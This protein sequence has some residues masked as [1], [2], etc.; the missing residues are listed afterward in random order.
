MGSSCR[1]TFVNSTIVLGSIPQK[2]CSSSSRVLK[3]GPW[4]VAGKHLAML[5]MLTPSLH[6]AS[7]M[8]TLVGVLQDAVLGPVRY[9]VSRCKGCP[10]LHKH[11]AALIA[12]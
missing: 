7:V 5:H 9:S 2:R 8:A 3:N 4:Q 12:S 10:G 6:N 11:G 1:H